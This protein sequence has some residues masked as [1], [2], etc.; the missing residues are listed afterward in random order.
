MYRN[1]RLQRAAYRAKKTHEEKQVELHA[2]LTLTTDA[3]DGQWSTSRS[4]RFITRKRPK[5]IMN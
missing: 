1:F 4:E 2:F 3:G 5:F